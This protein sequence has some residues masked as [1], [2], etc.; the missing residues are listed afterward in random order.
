MSSEGFKC[1]VC[2]QKNC[3]HKDNDKPVKITA[4]SNTYC[5]ICKGT[6]FTDIVYKADRSVEPKR[7]DKC[8]CGSGLK[9]KQCCIDTQKQQ[10]KT[11]CACV[12]KGY[13]KYMENRVKLPCSICG[14]EGYC[15]HRE[16]PD[17]V[18]ARAGLI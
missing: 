2:R 15:K 18:Y 7:N 10:S 8:P 4:L 16:H 5:K 11:V 1:T 14:E 6:G 9:Y 3:V 17:A 12:L 13:E